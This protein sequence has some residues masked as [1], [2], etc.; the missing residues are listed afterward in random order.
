MAKL[1]LSTP[2]GQTIK[3]GD[4]TVEGLKLPTG[5]GGGGLPSGTEDAGAPDWMQGLVD[6]Y[7]SGAVTA[8][9]INTIIGN[10]PELNS[11]EKDYYQTLFQDIISRKQSVDFEGVPL[12]GSLFKSPIESSLER[13]RSL[14]D[15]PPPTQDERASQLEDLQLE[16][17][18][19]EEL[20][21]YGFAKRQI[22]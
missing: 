18:S 12:L 1:A 20:E 14:R 4:K 16:G 17:A 3:V 6:R 10:R 13:Q 21:K 11:R 15:N 5:S 22:S 8:A 2:L 9:N 7:N 19:D